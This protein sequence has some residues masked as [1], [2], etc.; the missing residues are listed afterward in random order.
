MS[1]WPFYL[2]SPPVTHSSACRHG[3]V[4]I[5]QP[6]FERFSASSCPG[7]HQARI[8]GREAVSAMMAV[9]HLAEASLRLAARHPLSHWHAAA[10]EAG[11]A[12]TATSYESE[13]WNLC[14]NLA[15]AASTWLVQKLPSRPG[16]APPA[17]LVTLVPEVDMEPLFKS[18]LGLLATQVGGTAVKPSELEIA[19]AWSRACV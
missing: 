14:S 8:S 6:A 2:V 18:L 19:Q 4:E 9:V 13:P 7:E 17:R 5:A 12:E 10:A 3:E 11:S 15:L 1:T 16:G